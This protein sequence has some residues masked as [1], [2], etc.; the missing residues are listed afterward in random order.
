MPEIIPQSELIINTD[1]S[2]YHLNLLPDDIA[3]DIMTE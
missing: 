1:G 2:I 3:T